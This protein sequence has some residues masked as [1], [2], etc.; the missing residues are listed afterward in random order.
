MTGTQGDEY[1]RLA[2]ESSNLLMEYDSRTVLGRYEEAAERVRQAGKQRFRMGQIAYDAKEFAA[3]AEDW[4]SAAECFLQGSVPES[5][6][7]A[8]IAVQQMRAEDL[9][10]ARRLDLLAALHERENGLEQFRRNGQ[11]LVPVSG[12]RPPRIEAPAGDSADE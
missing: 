4:L 2:L 8:V 5:A 1:R 6:E 3:A 11:G 10:P 12:P 7:T 9:L